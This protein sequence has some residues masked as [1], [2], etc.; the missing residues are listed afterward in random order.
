MADHKLPR[1]VRKKTAKGRTYYYFDTGQKDEQG[2]PV[3]KRLPD[4]QDHPAFGIALAGA[5]RV[6]SMRAKGPDAK[7]LT[8]A[9]LVD[10]YQ[11]SP[12]FRSR[13]EGT[14]VSYNHYLKQIVDE[15]GEAPAD[16]VRRADAALLM[17]KRGK[18]PA[19]ANQIV[20]VLGALYAWGRRREHVTARPT[21]EL[22]LNRIGEHEP[23]P[24]WLVDEALASDDQLV[25]LAV[26]LLYFTA[27]RIGDTLRM[28]WSDIHG[29]RIAVKQEKGRQPLEIA[30]HQNLGSKLE[31]VPKRGLTILARPDGRPYGY[32][33]VLNRLKAFAAEH[34]VKAVPHG[35]RKN[36][37]NA[38][39]EAGCST[40]EVQ[41]VSGQSP[42]II[43][44]YAKK[45]NKTKLGDAAILR[46]QGRKA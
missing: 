34:Q 9:M 38:L 3:L 26:H 21:D 32:H 30:L 18:T 6:K 29:P 4:I 23:W 22:E 41:A 20:R 10:L 25:S 37:V 14:R 28:R 16:D 31:A 5:Y 12:Q 40:W 15:M 36:A 8:V 1:H 27:Q 42:Q 24:E 45:R 44:H 43:E 2:R 35:L 17:D 11:K 19:A 33:A 39:L 46:W 13:A 7:A